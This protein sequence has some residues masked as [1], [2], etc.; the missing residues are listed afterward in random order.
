MGSLLGLSEWPPCYVATY[1]AD[2]VNHVFK[3]LSL[4]I[5]RKSKKK[6]K[7]SKKANFF[8]SPSPDPFVCSLARLPSSNRQRSH[9][10][11][12]RNRLVLNIFWYCPF[13][14][15]YPPF[16]RYLTPRTMPQVSIEIVD[17]GEWLRTV[18]ATDFVLASHSFTVGF[19]STLRFY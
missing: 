6:K 17:A 16:L 15:L 2:I 8:V 18:W 10:C 1:E 13:W 5:R 3:D 7:E 19:L 12:S 14:N 9:S 4:S 11:F